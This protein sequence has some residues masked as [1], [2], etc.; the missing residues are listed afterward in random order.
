MISDCVTSPSLG[1]A[2]AAAAAPPPGGTPA[3]RSGEFRAW[4]GEPARISLLG[5]PSGS[6]TAQ[7]PRPA[8]GPPLQAESIYVHVKLLSRV[9]S[10]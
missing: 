2:G 9:Q 5:L 7:R 3:P 6:L 8:G 1:P 10:T 4:P